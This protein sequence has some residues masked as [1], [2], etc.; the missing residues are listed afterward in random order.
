M[1]KFVSPPPLKKENQMTGKFKN[2][3]RITSARWRDWDYGANAAYFV[4]ICTAHREWFFGEITNGEMQLSEIG[5]A[6]YGCWLQIPAHFPFVVLDTFVIMPNHV[7]GIIVINKPDN[8]TA[9]PP[10]HRA[11]HPVWQP[12]KFGPQSKNLASIIRGFKT[13]VTK[14]ARELEYRFAWQSRYHDHVIGNYHEHK[15]IA[16][17]IDANITN[18]HNDKLCGL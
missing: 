11:S 3:Y 13:G 4:T 17:Y 8:A 12:N 9:V 15:R 6:A 16:Y 10:Y 7:H 5:R 2:K 18:W 14:N 1:Q